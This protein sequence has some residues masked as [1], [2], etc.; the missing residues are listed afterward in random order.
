M[1]FSVL[2]S[3]SRGNCVYI[4]S[5]HSAI[6]IDAGF[7]GKEIANRLAS[8]DRDIESLDAIF[9]THE[10]HDHICGVGVMSRR[11]KIPVFANEGTFQ[12]AD[13]RLKKL[14][15]RDEFQTG[16]SIAFNDFHIRSFAVSHDTNDPVGFIIGNGHSSLGFCTDTGIVSRLIGHRLEG[17]NALILEFNHDPDLLMNGPY[18]PAL[19]QRVRSNQGHLSNGDAACLLDT[20]IHERLQ[21]I[22]LAH[23]S[24]TNNLPALAYGEAVGAVRSRLDENI[25]DISQPDK[26]TSLFEISECGPHF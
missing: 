7:S 25:L 6:L 1:R 13:K 3:G 17:C 5:A 14:F 24:E 8:I 4:E 26:P 15:K 20:L 22:V 19:K 10:H 18:P 2:G 16:D 11:C 9:L 21:R 23:L 12:G